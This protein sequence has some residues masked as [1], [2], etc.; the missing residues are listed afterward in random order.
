MPRRIAVRATENTD[1][2]QKDIAF[3]NNSPFDHA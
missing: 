2:D 3:K 1:I